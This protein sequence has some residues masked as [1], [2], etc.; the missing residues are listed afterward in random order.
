MHTLENRCKTLSGNVGI[1]D[2]KGNM[3]N[4]VHKKLLQYV[5]CN[6]TI[7]ASYTCNGYNV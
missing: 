4:S 5:V 1:G 3:K 2:K 6:G 7:T